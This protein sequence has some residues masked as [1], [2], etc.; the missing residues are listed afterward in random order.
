M[1]GTGF[2][3]LSV[4]LEGDG[5]ALVRMD[6]PDKRNAINDALIADLGAF[7]GA[8]PAGAKV[9]ILLGA[10]DHFCAGLDLAEHKERDPFGVMHH[11]QSWHR[12]FEALEFGGLP[13]VSVLHG[14]V[15]GG[16]MEIA[17][18]THVRVAEPTATYALPEGRRGIFVGGGASVRVSR[19]L[20]ADRMREMMLTGRRYDA[21][22][23][24]DL[25]LSHYLVGAGEGL[26]K[27]R[28]LARTIAGNAPISNYMML[29]ALARIG[30]MAMTEGLF[31]ESLATAMTQ[32][33]AHAREGMAAFLEKRA[34]D[35]KEES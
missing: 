30:D 24:Q 21:R 33:S 18:S 12:A 7:F 5:I 4:T 2:R 16:G 13:V 31:A 35:F 29:T 6:R 25:G 1:T 28:E 17:M 27:A 32:T 19:I 9:A 26:D 15:I 22:A 10:G 3:H 11:S 8:P 14:A 34:T 20:G 23:G